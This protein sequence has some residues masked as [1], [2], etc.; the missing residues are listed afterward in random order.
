MEN[1]FRECETDEQKFG[2]FGN[3]DSYYKSFEKDL[4][5]FLNENWS[6]W[7]EEQPDWFNAQVISLIPLA[8]LPKEALIEMGG[9]EGRKASILNMK[10]EEK[11]PKGKKKRRGSN[12]KIVPLEID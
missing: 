12:L 6:K 3:H 2:V 8:C 11:K 4:K 7:E 1:R 5:I 10:E 9:E